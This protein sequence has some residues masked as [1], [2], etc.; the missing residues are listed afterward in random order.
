MNIKILMN[1]IRLLVLVMTAILFFIMG[2]GAQ[3][4]WGHENE[5][6]KHCGVLKAAGQ[7]NCGGGYI[8]AKQVDGTFQPYLFAL[9]ADGTGR[10]H[11]ATF[12]V[13]SYDCNEFFDKLGIQ[14]QLTQRNHNS[15]DK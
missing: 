3:R 15:H 4:V 12:T 5:I 10:F 1:M 11:K 6:W 7:A 9:E 8:I 2:I 14:I 13:D